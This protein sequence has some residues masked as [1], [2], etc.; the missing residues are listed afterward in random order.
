MAIFFS[1]A[2]SLPK[3]SFLLVV[4]TASIGVHAGMQDGE[5]ACDQQEEVSA[6]AMQ[7][8][9]DSLNQD[10]EKVICAFNDGSKTKNFPVHYDLDRKDIAMPQDDLR[11]TNQGWTRAGECHQPGDIHAGI[12]LQ[13]YRWGAPHFCMKQA[14]IAQNAQAIHDKCIRKRDDGVEVVR[15]TKQSQYEFWIEIGESDNCDDFGS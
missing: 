13:T 3:L 7:L 2:K 8:A 5:I 6:Q 1:F 14:E 12:W 15:G 11:T 4:L 9:I 10:P